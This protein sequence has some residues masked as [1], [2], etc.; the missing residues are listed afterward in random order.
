M[1]VWKRLQRVGKRASKYQFTASYKEMMVE[2]TKKW[3]PHKLCIVWTRR[4]RRRSTQVLTWEPTIQNPYKGLVTWT[5]PENIEI[6]VTLFRESRQ[7]EFEDK[8]W[9]F[10]IEDISK[11]GRRKVLASKSINM[12][13]FASFVPTQTE[14]K[15]K[16]KPATKKIVSAYIHLTLSCVFVREGKATDEDMQSVAS[17]MSLGKPSDI[18]NIDDFLEED[19]ADKEDNTAK[20]SELAAKLA[21]IERDADD[22]DFGQLDASGS[23]QNNTTS[24]LNPFDQ[25]SFGDLSKNSNESLEAKPQNPFDN[26]SDS[27]NPFGDDGGD[28]TGNDRGKNNDPTCIFEKVGEMKTS[29]SDGT[30]KKA[31]TLDNFRR[32][33]GDFKMSPSGSPKHGSPKNSPKSRGKS[34]TLKAFPPSSEPKKIERKSSPRPIYQGT[35]PSTPPE[36]KDVPLIVRPITPPDEIE[37][38]S[39]PL[40]RKRGS[41]KVDLASDEAKDAGQEKEEDAANLGNRNA[42][43]PLDLNKSDLGQQKKATPSQDLLEWCKEVTKGYKGVKVTNMTTSWRNGLAFC[44][45]VHHFSPSLIDF[46]TLSPHDIKGN[47]KKAFDAA[48][49]CGVPKVIEPS[50][51]VLLTVPDKLSVM[52]YLYQLRSYFT[53]QTLEVQQ[54]GKNTKESTYMI[55]DFDSDL[56]SKISKEMYG[57]EIPL[58]RRNERNVLKKEKSDSDISAKSRSSSEEPSI[59]TSASFTISKDRGVSLLKENAQPDGSRKMKALMTRKQLMNPFDSDE[60]EL[61]SPYNDIVQSSQ[62]LNASSEEKLSDR[63]P[64]SDESSKAARKEERRKLREERRKQEQQDQDQTSEADRNIAISP[65]RS[66]PD[67]RTPTSPVTPSSPDS[68]SGDQP[69]SDKYDEELEDVDNVDS[70]DVDM[71]DDLSDASCD[72]MLISGDA[73]SN[74][75]EKL[76]GTDKTPVIGVVPNIASSQQ[77][78]TSMDFTSVPHSDYGGD[79]VVCDTPELVHEEEKPRSRHEELKERAR[80]LLE[81]AR[82]DAAL[83]GASMVTPDTPTAGGP[84]QKFSGAEKDEERQKHLRE[85]ARKL[86][87]EARAGVGKPEDTSPTLSED[88]RPRSATDTNLPSRDFKFYKYKRNKADGKESPSTGEKTN[89]RLKKIMLSRPTLATALA[90]TATKLGSKDTDLRDMAAA[91]EDNPTGRPKSLSIGSESQQKRQSLTSPKDRKTIHVDQFLDS[92]GEND[93]SSDSETDD[94]LIPKVQSPDD[95]LLDTSQYVN[96]EMSALEREQKQIDETADILERELRSAM[97]D[98]RKEDEERLMQEWFVLVNKKNAL[99]RRQ[100]QLNILEKEDDLERRFDLLN[101]E[102]RQMMTIEDW[103]KT[104]AQKKREKLLLEELVAIV[105]KRDELVQ[106]LDNQERAIEDDEE[107]ERR[108]NQGNLVKPEKERCAIQ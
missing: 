40:A 39:R 87:A 84:V 85:R 65:T 72:N 45:I 55:G 20:F 77:E 63:S 19:E 70:M 48:A 10:V 21:A 32:G 100:M 37:A 41:D 47:N 6:T 64:R 102:L 75:T 51:M 98:G 3:Q 23:S 81:Q 73:V 22:D 53:G 91:Q 7:D 29:I 4:S 5:V 60:E 79:G 33:S 27:T 14:V 17:L 49:R 2:C 25:S 93:G 107:L 83:K 69:E 42:L 46:D 12:K 15:V 8:D 59:P 50:D 67:R 34:L 38:A 101:R 28:E 36:E 104:E 92:D 78:E 9:T 56:N 54:I 35:P 74:D 18:G 31:M 58:E 68:A 1:S 88:G 94:V 30:R 80:L 62:S 24:S 13:D 44:A 89:V 26:S 61:P 86:I 71:F 105:N 66:T 96:S 108:V 97:N 11:S 106:H 103:Q 57:K 76:P 52:T 99:I 43:E 95:P 82:R 90:T 16:M